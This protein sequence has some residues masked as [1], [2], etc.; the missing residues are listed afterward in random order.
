MKNEED[1]ELGSWTTLLWKPGTKVFSAEESWVV[2]E[3]GGCVVGEGVGGGGI[4]VVDFGGSSNL[5]NLEGSGATVEAKLGKLGKAVK[6]LVLDLEGAGVG[7][8][9]PIGSLGA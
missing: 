4:G 5:T 2:G 7:L 3:G 8:G 1:W 6:V 9:K